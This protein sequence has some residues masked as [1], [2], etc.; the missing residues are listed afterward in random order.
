VGHGKQGIFCTGQVQAFVSNPGIAWSRC[1]VI[2][3]TIESTAVSGGRLVRVP[4]RH[5][6]RLVVCAPVP[7]HGLDIWPVVFRQ[8][9]GLPT[10]AE[11]DVFLSSWK[12][13]GWHSDGPPGNCS[14]LW[15]PFARGI[16]GIALDG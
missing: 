13:C 6:F 9:C 1:Q 8:A 15:E 16:A 4:G 2:L 7:D 3:N 10:H 14:L 5:P 11:R 12:L